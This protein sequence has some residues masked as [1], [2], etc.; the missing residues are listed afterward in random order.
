MAKKNTKFN[1]KNLQFDRELE[2]PDMNFDMPLPTDDRKPESSVKKFAK[3]AAQGAKDAVFSTA[4]IKKAIKTA[5]PDG[6]GQALGLAEEAGGMVKDLYNTSAR[7]LK[8]SLSELQRA[9]GRL[10]PAGEKYIPDSLNKNLKNWAAQGK[11]Q[12]SGGGEDYRENELQNTMSEV[13]NHQVKDLDRREKRQD[14]KNAV[15][16]NID[17]KRHRDQLGQLD[18]IRV[19]TAALQ[20]YL[21]LDATYKRKSLELQYRHYFVAADQLAEAKRMNAQ[22]ETLLAD[23]RKNTSLPDFVKLNNTERIKEVMRN[24]FIDSFADGALAKRREFVKN[25]GASLAGQVK[26]RVQRFSDGFRTAAQMGDSLADVRDLGDGMGPDFSLAGLAGSL[27]GKYGAEALGNAAFKKIKKPLADKFPALDRISNKLSYKTE[28]APQL[29]REWAKGN[30]GDN[31]IFGGL[32]RIIKDATLEASGGPKSDLN[33]DSLGNIQ[34]PMPLTRQS[35]KSIN[36]VIPGYLAMILREQQIARTGDTSI[37]LTKYDFK[38]NRFD[39]DS[40]IK[41]SLFKSLVSDDSV[42]RNKEGADNLLKEIDPDGKLSEEQRAVLSRQLMED[43]L[44]NRPGSK[45]RL[46]DP[47]QYTGKSARWGHD[48]AEAFGRYFQGDQNNSRQLSFSRAYNRLG[49]DVDYKQKN[50]Q[51]YANAGLMDFLRDSGIVNDNGTIDVNKLNEYGWGAEYNPATGSVTP[52]G[53]GPGPRPAPSPDAQRRKRAAPPPMPG[54]RPGAAATPQPSQTFD[55]DRLD[56][57]LGKMNPNDNLL[58]ISEILERIDGRISNGLLTYS[59]LIG[60]QT[61]SDDSGGGPGPEGAG[62]DGGFGGIPDWLRRFRGPSPDAALKW[63][64][65]S[66]GSLFKK[67]A[68]ASLAGFKAGKAWLGKQAGVVKGLANK[69]AGVGK[70]LINS[71][72]DYVTRFRDVYVPGEEFPRILGAKM[73][74]GLYFDD[75]TGTPI[76]SFR[77]I[78][79]AVYEFINGEK[80]Y[81]L[82]EDEAHVAYAKSRAGSQ[83]LASLGALTGKLKDFGNR[84]SGGVLGMIATAKDT[85]K[86]VFNLGM[87]KLDG[88]RDVYVHGRKGPALLAVTMRAGAY[89]SKV[90]GKVIKK[91]SDID[92]P[93]AQL[94]DGHE[95]IKLTED[96]LGQGLL[97]AEGKPLRVGLSRI[98]GAIGDAVKTGWNVLKNAGR[99]VRDFLG[100]GFNY[101]NDII[102][103]KGLIIFG[104]KE[105]LDHVA[106]IRKLLEER[107]PGGKVFGDSDGDGVRDGSVEDIR[108]KR[109]DKTEK[110]DEEKKKGDEDKKGGLLAGLAGLLGFGKKK[111]DDEEEEK[112]D[113]GGWLDDAADVADIADWAD[114]DGN[115][116]GKKGGK[117]RARGGRPGRPKKAGFLKRA[118]GGMK[119]GA[120][121]VFGGAGRWLT[122]GGNKALGGARMA[123]TAATLAL[124][125]PTAY[126]LATDKTMTGDKKT[127]EWADLG[128]NLAGGW[129]GMEMGAAAGALGGPLGVVIGGALGGLLGGVFGSKLTTG[130]KSMFDKKPGPLGLL[131]I[132][133]YG[134]LKDDNEYIQQILDMESK[135]L[136]GVTFDE[137]GVAR[138]DGDKV[139]VNDIVKSFGVDLENPVQTGRWVDWF[140]NRFKLVFL[141][142]LSALKKIKDGVELDKVDQGKL[143]QEEQKKFLEIVKWPNGPYDYMGSPFPALERLHAGR[144]EVTAA[145]AYAREQI[146]KGATKSSTDKPGGRAGFQMGDPLANKATEAAK[147]TAAAAATAG[148]VGAVDATLGGKKPGETPLMKLLPD[149]ANIDDTGYAKTGGT[150]SAVAGAAAVTQTFQGRV[151]AVTVVRFKTYGLKEMEADKVRSLAQLED[152]AEKYLKFNSQGKAE[153]NGDPNELFRQAGPGFGVDSTNPTQTAAWLTWFRQRFLPVYLNYATALLSATRKPKLRDAL[154]ALQPQGELNVAL[155][156]YATNQPSGEAVWLSPYTPWPGYALNFDVTTTNANVQALKDAAKDGPLTEQAAAD[157]D[158]TP[159][160]DKKDK[161]G[162]NAADQAAKESKGFWDQTKNAASSAWDATKNAVGA[163]W[164]GTKKLAGDVGGAVAGAVNAGMDAIGMGRSIE[165]PGKGSGGD[166]NQIPQPKGDGSAAA[167][168]ELIYAASKMAGVDPN[169]M[170]TMAA[171]ESGFKSS[172]KAGTSS[173]TGLYQFISGTWQTML[174]KYGAKYG[175]APNTSPTDPRANALMGAEFIKENVNALKS[176]KSNITDTDVYMAH[177]MGSGGAKKFLKALNDNPQAIA[178]QLMPDAARANK[179]IY[180]EKNGTPKTMMGVYQHLNNLVRNKG[181]Q[182]GLGSGG[183]TEAIV[184]TKPGA[185]KPGA[186][187]AAATTAGATSTGPTGGMGTDAPKPGAIPTGGPGA[188]KQSPIASGPLVPNGGYNASVA[189]TAASASGGGS[190]PSGTYTPP[191]PQSDD[192]RREQLAVQQRATQ[193][194]QTISTDGLESISKAHLT[195]TKSMADTLSK[196]LAVLTS[197]GGSAPVG[198]NTPNNKSPERMSKPPVSVAKPT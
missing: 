172:V 177:F 95:E 58:K 74:Q 68:T 12:S 61:V 69:V 13:F 195:V 50:I 57:S 134:F 189:G 36:E 97:D 92:G 128:G 164:E 126:G 165:H 182:F 21:Q 26:D 10:L 188:L 4:F 48:Y 94:I 147:A 34:E 52:N 150:I 31:S 100:R 65:Q 105:L 41:K 9:T 116:R 190:T 47:W 96:E 185:T 151:D 108:R 19:S 194:Q 81:V 131:R 161:F 144:A 146:E 149:Y 62:P 11:N 60:D 183:G 51:E 127:T 78:T 93:V 77:D 46:M 114:G 80:H 22:T 119:K 138:L 117:S 130:I 83:L 40:N 102:T 63:Y 14:I 42:R 25:F 152:A 167:L 2:L 111:K 112:D 197:G 184:P 166:I 157:K 23:I 153:F 129:A 79:G 90:S 49:E 17:Q 171:I 6:F 110:E 186:S 121:K 156:V 85:A 29:M 120:G 115:D 162:A 136:P 178:A 163:A 179:G 70:D 101:M 142:H 8:S 75:A 160:S 44:N 159:G 168:K 99:N 87:G 103:K 73:K 38:K 145:E 45:E 113:G 191:S 169:M 104:G 133:Q 53:P 154:A 135:L 15:K 174:K 175:I 132:A 7:E 30:K 140:N 1:L 155:A 3:G 33:I 148:T 35:N 124:A 88:P 107:L 158:N 66:V 24:Q 173:A 196:I 20:N 98:T 125:A 180:Y 192:I 37:E 55:W 123:G 5:L 72:A 64:Q 18:A 187:T 139:P 86:S 82:T 198:A 109:K 67:G 106:A 28:N 27:S 89:Y 39:S 84:M 32:V 76:K 141:T 16:E 59:I 91:V 143:S 54:P 118:F 71:G 193:A 122:G 181:K 56:T 176:V 43:N 137:R 170:M